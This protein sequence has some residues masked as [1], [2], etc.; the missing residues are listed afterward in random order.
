MLEADIS[1]TAASLVNDQE[2]GP[3]CKLAKTPDSRSRRFNVRDF[4]QKSRNVEKESYDTIVVSGQGKANY[5]PIGQHA[6]T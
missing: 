2:N 6:P 5:K 3:G 1:T 4:V